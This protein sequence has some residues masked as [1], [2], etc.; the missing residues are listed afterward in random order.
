MKK[1]DIAAKM[2]ESVTLL[3]LDGYQL[4]LTEL[5]GGR[6]YGAGYTVLARGNEREIIFITKRC[7]DIECEDGRERMF[8]TITITRSH[9]ELGKGETLEHNYMWSSDWEEHAVESYKFWCID[10]WG[11]RDWY[12]ESFEEALSC[13]MK[14]RERNCARF[15]SC[16]V[17]DFEVTDELMRIV[18]K[19]KGFKTVRR[20]DVRVWK[21]VGYNGSAEYIIDNTRSGNRVTLSA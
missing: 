6:G 15:T 16:N 7:E 21:K 10:E 13:R 18:R 1:M 3:L 8:S 20:D 12:T 2:S 14:S 17:K 11:N 5:T 9:I 4:S 19:V